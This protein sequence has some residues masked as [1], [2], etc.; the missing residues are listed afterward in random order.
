MALARARVRRASNFIDASRMDR[1]SITV[2][3]MAL[4]SAAFRDATLT[5]M[6]PNSSAFPAPFQVRGARP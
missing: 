3:S 2:R 1:S 5:S 6:A 4:G